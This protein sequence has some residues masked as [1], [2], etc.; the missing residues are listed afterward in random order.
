MYVCI[1]IYIHL[2]IHTYIHTHIHIQIHTYLYIYIYI[3]I[4]ILLSMLLILSMLGC[5][6]GTLQEAD[7][8]GHVVP[9][10][11]RAGRKGGS[12]HGTP[13]YRSTCQTGAQ[14]ARHVRTPP[15]QAGFSRSS[16]SPQ[17]WPLDTEPRLR[18]LAS[19]AMRPASAARPASQAGQPGWAAWLAGQPGRA[20]RQAWS[21]A[22]RPRP[23]PS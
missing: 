20:A 6:L 9:R 3:C 10:G 5:G 14:I 16:L 2:Y 15:R 8:L 19:P 18:R 12:C 13:P 21:L 7:Q 17:A 4:Y 22:R 23:R 11:D 1:Y